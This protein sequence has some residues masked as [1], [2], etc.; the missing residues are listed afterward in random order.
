MHKYYDVAIRRNDT[1]EVRMCRQD[2]D[3]DDTN[4]DGHIYYWTEGNFG[5][6]C[7]RELE[8]LRA[9]GD[10]PL[11]DSVECGGERFSALYALLPDGRRVPLDD[12][13]CYGRSSCEAE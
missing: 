4:D 8:F 5:C 2:V 9:G 3:W 7:N 11:F 13:A 12:D 6:D 10:D 1:G